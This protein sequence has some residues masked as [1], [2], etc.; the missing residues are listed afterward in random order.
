MSIIIDG[1]KLAEGYKNEIAQYVKERVEKDLRVPC[2]AAVI[3]GNDGGSIYYMKNQQA[4]CN[5][6]GVNY[7]TVSLNEDI[8]E[9]ELLKVIKELNYDKNIDGIIIMMPLPKNIREKVITDAISPKKDVDGLTDVNT[10]LFYK[11]E[12]CFVPCT[13]RS[14]LEIVKNTGISIEGKNAVVI[15]RSNIVGK[16][17]FQ[18]LLKENATVTICHSRTKGIK[19]ICRKADI[20]VSAIGKPGFVTADFVKEGAVVVDV[21]TTMVNNKIM[22]DV[23]FEN[24]KNIA[25]YV[26]P[27]P[28]GVGSLTTTMLIK[29][30]CE[31]L[32]KNEC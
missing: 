4:L 15:G 3:V 12:K 1:K 25:S 5:K 6:L 26:T 16:P 7:R 24:V 14:V 28:G 32:E 11:G 17:A 21:G 10:G 19:D 2:L 30:V 18:L 20:L 23:D 27:V 31:A 22:G 29:N 9:L 8:E 13:P